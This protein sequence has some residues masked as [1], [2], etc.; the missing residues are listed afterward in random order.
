MREAAKDG[1]IRARRVEEINVFEFDAA[2]ENVHFCI[3]VILINRWL[4]VDDVEGGLASSLC[5]V[6]SC[7]GRSS[8]SKREETDEHTEEDGEAVTS[9]VLAILSRILET[10]VNPD[11]TDGEAV[12]VAQVN[13]EEEKAEGEARNAARLATGL[14]HTVQEASVVANLELLLA[15]AND[16][17]NGREGL[18]GIA[19]RLTVSLGRCNCTALDSSAEKA[20]ADQHHWGDSKHGERKSPALDEA[21]CEARDAHADGV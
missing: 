6:D 11:C 16:H 2:L 17:A 15:K 14:R 18:F 1:L 12:S 5:D 20:H 8:T 4:S 9:Q 13:H 19:C 10:S 21:N 7:H 3:C